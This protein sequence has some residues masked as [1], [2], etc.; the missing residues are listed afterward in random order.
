MRLLFKFSKE[1]ESLPKAEVEAVLEGEGCQHTVIFDEPG[2]RMVETATDN[3][4]F[5]NRLALTLEVDKILADSVNLGI[6][7]GAVFDQLSEYETF[8]VVSESKK[9]EVELGDILHKMG[10]EVNL[11]DPEVRISA[12]LFGGRYYAGIRIPIARDF[13]KRKPQ[14]RPYVHPTSMH[15]KLAR[16]LVNLARVGAGDTVLDP[17]CGTGGILI[18]AGLIDLD[19]VGWDISSDMVAGCKK[20]LKHYDIKAEV[21]RKDALTGVIEDVDAIVTDPPYGRSSYSS[22]D[23][24]SLY[25]KFLD[26]ALRM[27][28]KG[29]HIVIVSPKDCRLAFEGYDIVGSYEVRVH[30]SLTRKISVLLKS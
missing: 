25:T 6:L 29:G 24:T 13:E 19:T 22:E 16:A 27:L 4:I 17:F 30:K 26:N 12:R 15:P 3:S 5:V 1:H 20:N 2:F 7:A 8:R 11:K 23:I 21:V 18:E 10:L 28:N 14:M 9:V